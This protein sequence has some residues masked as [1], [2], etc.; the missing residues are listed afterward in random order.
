MLSGFVTLPW[1]EAALATGRKPGRRRLTPFPL[2]FR[3]TAVSTGRL[4]RACLQKVVTFRDKRATGWP[5]T[6]LTAFFAPGGVVS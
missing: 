4:R 1:V 2:Q 6:L 3:E 5:G